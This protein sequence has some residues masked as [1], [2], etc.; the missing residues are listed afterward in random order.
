MRIY[1]IAA[2]IFVLNLVGSAFTTTMSIGDYKELEYGQ[3]NI[4]EK[5]KTITAETEQKSQNIIDQMLADLN[6]LVE[7]VR[8][9]IFGV[10]TFIS[11]FANALMVE[12]MLRSM[13]PFLMVDGMLHPFVWIIIFII[14]IVYLIGLVEVITGREI[15]N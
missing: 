10:Q 1:E 2:F 13:F 5:I 11:I 8:M 7:N 14:W 6:W 9:V 4:Q 3:E 12:P 15:E